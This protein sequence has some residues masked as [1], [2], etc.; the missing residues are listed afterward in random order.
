MQL[1]DDNVRA[2]RAVPSATLGPADGPVIPIARQTAG[3]TA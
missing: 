3:V 1:V 2:V